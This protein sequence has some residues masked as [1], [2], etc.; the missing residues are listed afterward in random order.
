MTNLVGANSNDAA[1]LAR[2]GYEQELK[3]SLGV[4]GNVA[5]GFATVSPVVGLYAVVQVG[6]IVAGP[7]WVWVLP[8]CLLGQM[9]LLC[10]YAELASQFPISGGAYQWTRRLLGPSYAWATGWLSNCAI[11]AAN[12]TVAFLAAPW[13]FALFGWEPTPGRIVAVAAAFLLGCALINSLGID[14][15]RRVVNLGIVAEAVASIGIG[16]TLLLFFHRHGF[17]LLTDTMG[18]E[19]LSDGSKISAFLAALAVGGWAFIG[20]DACVAA[21]EETKNAARHVPRAIWL[22]LISVGGLVILNAVAAE[23]AHPDPAA[24]ASGKDIDPV[25]TA[26]VTS[27]GDWSSKPFI[28]VVIIAFI[29]CMLASQAAA[30]DQFTLSLGMASSLPRPYSV[31]LIDIRYLWAHS[32]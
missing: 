28:A 2:L 31:G 5:M 15:L 32:W 26:V 13:F 4:L 23:L 12:T 17:S 25:T 3:R 10:V 22:S 1:D 27:F 6:T 29:A 21:S 20:F 7:A 30:P 19:A 14:L 18:A 24:I 11:I 9:L 8:I 16:L